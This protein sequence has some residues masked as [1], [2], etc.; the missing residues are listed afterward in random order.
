MLVV[1]MGAQMVLLQL[2]ILLMISMNNR[3]IGGIVLH[4][5]QQVAKHWKL[6]AMVATHQEFGL[7]DNI[8]M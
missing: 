2:Y 7:Q 8:A 1:T 4:G 6:V 3:G 5:S